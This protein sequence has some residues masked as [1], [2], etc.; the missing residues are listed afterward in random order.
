[1]DMRTVDHGI[2]G[3][4]LLRR[5][6]SAARIPIRSKAAFLWGNIKPDL[7]Y[8]T[9]LKGFLRERVLRGII[10]NKAAVVSGHCCRKQKKTIWGFWGI[11]GWEN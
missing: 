3:I 1:M 2:L 5:T 9:Y 11:I 7:N 8:A 10:L 6:A 4:Y